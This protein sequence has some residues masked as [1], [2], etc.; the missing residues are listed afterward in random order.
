MCG[1]RGGLYLFF[2]RRCSDVENTLEAMFVAHNIRPDDRRFMSLV[3]YILSV[4]PIHGA[5]SWFYY[6]DLNVRSEYFCQH[7]IIR[8]DPCRFFRC[9]LLCKKKSSASDLC[10]LSTRHYSRSYQTPLLTLLWHRA[11]TVLATSV[12]I[13]VLLCSV[14]NFSLQNRIDPQGG[15]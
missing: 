10:R 12:D 9:R 13:P 8:R 14:S 5:P 3:V 4:V 1:V 7:D 11:G 2:K 6:F 15:P